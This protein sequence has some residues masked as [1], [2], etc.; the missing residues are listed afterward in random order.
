[1]EL[2]AMPCCSRPHVLERTIDVNEFK[3]PSTFLDEPWIDASWFRPHSCQ[4]LS[5]PCRAASESSSLIGHELLPS[6]GQFRFAAFQKEKELLLLPLTRSFPWFPASALHTRPQLATFTLV[7]SCTLFDHCHINS[8]SLPTFTSPP[9][10]ISTGV[11]AVRA[12]S[13]HVGKSFVKETL[14]DKALVTLSSPSVTGPFNSSDCSD[15][16]GLASARSPSLRMRSRL[17]SDP[18]NRA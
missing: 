14:T 4:A 16:D 10:E 3:A 7:G 1:M 17:H 5:R 2:H 18:I 15:A 12:L 13:R 8:S 11:F 9:R 6:R